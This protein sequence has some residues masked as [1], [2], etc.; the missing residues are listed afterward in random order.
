[1]NRNRQLRWR[2]K[3]IKNGYNEAR[4]FRYLMMYNKIYGLQQENAESKYPD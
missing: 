2:E 3:E 4:R 1:M